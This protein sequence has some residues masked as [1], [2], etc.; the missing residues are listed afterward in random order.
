MIACSGQ[1]LLAACPLSLIAEEKAMAESLP[2]VH[3]YTDDTGVTH[4]ADAALPWQHSVCGTPPVPRWTT[5]FQD[6]HSLGYVRAAAGYV[7]DWHPAPRKQFAIVL[8]GTMEVE[9][10][11]GE[12]R[13]FTPGMILLVTDL[14][15]HGHQTRAVGAED[16]FMVQVPVP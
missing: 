3:L 16:L 8:S 13:V 9:A 14:T 2:Y 10:G 12:T 11:D 1:R 5:A 7:S 6:A 4:F 15:G